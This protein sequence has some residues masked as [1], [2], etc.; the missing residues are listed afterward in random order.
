MIKP[1]FSLMRDGFAVVVDE[2]RDNWRV[3]AV[4]D[5]WIDANNYLYRTI[6]AN[7]GKVVKVKELQGKM[8]E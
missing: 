6:G 5:G 4:F 1:Q 3:A 2:N 8:E 7:R